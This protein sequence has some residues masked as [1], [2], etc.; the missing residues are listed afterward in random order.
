MCAV[1][2]I[3]TVAFIIHL[4]SF[5]HTE[6]TPSH[7]TWCSWWGEMGVRAQEKLPRSLSGLKVCCELSFKLRCVSFWITESWM[8]S[9]MT[10]QCWITWPEETRAVSW[11]PSALGKCLR[12]QATA[13]PSRKNP[14]GRD[15][16]TS[17]SFSCLEMVGTHIQS[18]SR[19]HIVTFSLLVACL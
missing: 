11:S 17:P 9:S 7:W 15:R 18:H 5:G 12:P 4:F 10:L 3:E 13:S 8:P 16:W 1:I 14:S 19:T 6:H 2:F